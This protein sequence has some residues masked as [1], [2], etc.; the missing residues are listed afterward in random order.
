MTTDCVTLWIGDSLGPVERACARSV[1]RQ[2]HRLSL[3]CYGTLRGVP[4]GVE[5]RDASAII[6]QSRILYHRSG[7]PGLF[8]DWFRLEL[9]R[10]GLGTWIDLDMYLIAP[11]DLSKSYL[12]AEEE[13][14]LINNAVL[15]LPSDCPMLPLLLE[16]FEQGTTPEWLPWYWYYPA[17]VRELISGRADVRK[18]PW[19]STGAYGLT[20]LARRFGLYS[21][22]YPPE[23]FYPSGWRNAAWITDP[24]KALTDIVTANTLGVHLSNECIRAYKDSPAPEGSF[25]ERLQLEG[26]E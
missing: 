20:S 2:G 7:S 12:L 3:Y 5:L 8:A 10:Q 13:P 15:R 9:L 23:A 1:M 6:P 17:K 21:Q 22:A 25:L 18:M 4:Q 19:G 16:P 11:I 24:S 26:R 14:G